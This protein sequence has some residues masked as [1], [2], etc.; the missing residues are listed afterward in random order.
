MANWLCS[1]SIRLQNSWKSNISRISRGMK[2]ID[3][4]TDVQRSNHLIQTYML[5]LLRNFLLLWKLLT[6][7][8]INEE[9]ALYIW[10]ISNVWNMWVGIYRRN[11]LIQDMSR[12]IYMYYKELFSCLSFLIILI[13]CDP[14]HSG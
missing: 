14:N 6:S 8:F 3:S 12:T 5:N 9:F 2:L 13:C 7:Y 4:S 11:L 1:W 10:R